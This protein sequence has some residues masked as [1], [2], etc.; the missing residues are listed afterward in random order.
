M[1]HRALQTPFPQR[2]GVRTPDF[3][4]EMA[5]CAPFLWRFVTNRWLPVIGRCFL[6]HGTLP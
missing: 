2:K 5:L 1:V 6:P 4:A 3:S